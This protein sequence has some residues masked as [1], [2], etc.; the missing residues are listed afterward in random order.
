MAENIH[1]LVFRPEEKLA[2]KFMPELLERIA[3]FHRL[4]P[5]AT[6]DHRAL[7]VSLTQHFV[8]S[9]PLLAGLGFIQEDPETENLSL[10][11]HIV[12]Q[13]QE[14]YGEKSLVVLQYA[15]DKGVPRETHKEGM[16]ILDSVARAQECGAIVAACPS[17]AIARIHRVYHGFERHATL[18]RRPVEVQNGR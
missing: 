12:W 17:E 18:M 7:A 8:C 10:V 13:I 5:E 11:G 3:S 6:M 9:S 16:A 2:W 15:L 4:V 14:S 1:L